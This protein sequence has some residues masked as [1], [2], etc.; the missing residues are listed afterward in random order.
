MHECVHVRVLVRAC[1]ASVEVCLEV[2]CAEVQDVAAVPWP[3]WRP[4]N[5]APKIVRQHLRILARAVDSYHAAAFGLEHPSY[6][7][8]A[9]L[10]CHHQWCVIQRRAALQVLALH[11]RMP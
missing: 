9:T 5:L 10:G 8:V 6:L 3:H 4:V 2:L 7:C 1:L 11:I